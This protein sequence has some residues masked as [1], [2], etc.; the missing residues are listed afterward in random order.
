MNTKKALTMGLSL[1]LAGTLLVGCG[2][3]NNSYTSDASGKTL[4]IAGLDGGYG[5]KGWEAVAK[6]FE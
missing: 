5:T 2:G 1:V 3:N 4:K 6:A